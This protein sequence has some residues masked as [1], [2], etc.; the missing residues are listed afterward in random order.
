MLSIAKNLRAR[1]SL[2]RNASLVMMG[3]LVTALLALA[4]C[5]EPGDLT[6]VPGISQYKGS[7]EYVQ[8]SRGEYDSDLSADIRID[9]WVSKDAAAQYQRIAPEAHDSGA[10]LPYGTVI[11]REV[12]DKKTARLQKL[13]M[14]YKGPPGV[15]PEIGDWQY[16]VTDAVG[17]PLLNDDGTEKKG[18]MPECRGCHEE[19]G[20]ED[21]F[22]FGVPRNVR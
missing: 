20:A 6:V 13:T 11:I 1:I 9:V 10:S 12:H 16:A 19:R 15:A 8:V 14:M 5:M 7:G 4:G 3:A 17:V 22:L 2:S 18:D 21:D